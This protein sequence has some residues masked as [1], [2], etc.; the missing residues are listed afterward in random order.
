[1]LLT[2][3]LLQCYIIFVLQ[4]HILYRT[5]YCMSVLILINFF[6]FLALC[7]LFYAYVRKDLKEISKFEL[8]RNVSLSLISKNFNWFD[9][10]TH[11]LL[12]QI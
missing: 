3:S 1:M 12:I 10:V 8:M 11:F 5:V 2:L 6:L 9:L 4:R 7:I